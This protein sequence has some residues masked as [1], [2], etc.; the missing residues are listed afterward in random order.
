MPTANFANDKYPAILALVNHWKHEKTKQEIATKK[1]QEEAKK[2]TKVTLMF[3]DIPSNHQVTPFGDNK[4]SNTLIQGPKKEQQ[5]KESIT[6]GDAP[7]TTV[8]QTI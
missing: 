4:D 8:H 3:G 6:L 5:P 7:I 1:A 2:T